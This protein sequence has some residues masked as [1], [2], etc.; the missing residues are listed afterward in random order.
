MFE[1]ESE[2][3]GGVGMY[4]NWGKP[5]QTAYGY[6]FFDV[7]YSEEIR[8]SKHCGPLYDKPKRWYER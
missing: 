2:T 7:D 5:T 1:G 8:G 4:V 3:G 6:Q